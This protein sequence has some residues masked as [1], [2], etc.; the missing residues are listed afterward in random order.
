[1]RGEADA[2]RDRDT[3]RTKAYK[4]CAAVIGGI[5]LAGVA[6]GLFFGSLVF[7]M[8]WG[9]FGAI[10]LR[11]PLVVGAFPVSFCFASIGVMVGLLVAQPDDV[12]FVNNFLIMPMT[13]YRRLVLPRGKLAASGAAY[14]DVL[15][16][17]RAEPPHAERGVAAGAV[18]ERADAG[19]AWRVVFRGRGRDLPEIQRMRI[20]HF[21]FGK[22]TDYEYFFCRD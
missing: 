9:V 21:G 14:R 12:A 4:S 20:I 15:S 3:G 8:A 16:H 11:M 2:V 13:F 17:R 10:E 19:R 5:V 7:L 22:E 6:R 18:A 1:M